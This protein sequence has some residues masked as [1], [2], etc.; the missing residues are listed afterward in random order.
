MLV[1]GLLVG[2][3]ASSGTFGIFSTGAGAGAPTKTIS[4]QH[5]L[6]M[7]QIE[8]LQISVDMIRMEQ[9]ILKSNVSEA[10]AYMSV[11]MEEL[12]SK[13]NH[14][15]RTVNIMKQLQG[16]SFVETMT[17]LTCSSTSLQQKLNDLETELYRSKLSITLLAVSTLSLIIAAIGLKEDLLFKIARSDGTDRFA[18]KFLNGLKIFIMVSALMM[19]VCSF[20]G[21][22][23]TEHD[24]TMM[25]F[26]T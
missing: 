14:I 22:G 17:N 25:N 16:K 20:S 9:I 24:P 7:D 11:L 2:I 18:K 26:Q 13:Q 5:S 3:A 1:V 23:A 10:H 8:S 15:G 4:L 6:I 21:V 12:G 19:F